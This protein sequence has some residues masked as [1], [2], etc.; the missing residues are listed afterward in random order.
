M[1]VCAAQNVL[2][3]PSLLGLITMDSHHL[4]Q[5]YYAYL[6]IDKP[7]SSMFL[8]QLNNPHWSMHIRLHVHSA[9]QLAKRALMA[10]RKHCAPVLEVM[11][12]A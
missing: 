10:T 1:H 12:D 4:G 2:V 9:C 8:Y 7:S 3:H 6:L 5:V 11:S